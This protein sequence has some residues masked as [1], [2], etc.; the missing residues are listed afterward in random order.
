METSGLDPEITIRKIAVLPIKLCPPL[1]LHNDKTLKRTKSPTYYINHELALLKKK[2]NRPALAG[3][4]GF[5]L[6]IFA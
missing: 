1:L 4:L 2:K 6:V 3:P 5:L